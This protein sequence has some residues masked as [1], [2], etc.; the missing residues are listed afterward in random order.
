[1]ICTMEE[2][3]DHCNKPPIDLYIKTSHKCVKRLI[4]HLWLLYNSLTLD[5]QANACLPIND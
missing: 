2:V 5:N 4:S 1:M 3:I